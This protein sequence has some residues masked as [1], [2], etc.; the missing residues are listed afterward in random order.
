MENRLIFLIKGAV[1]EDIG[2]SL[3]Y[4]ARHQSRV[5]WG[6]ETLMVTGCWLVEARLRLLTR[7]DPGPVF[8]A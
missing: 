6:G 4:S 7:G 5:R 2:F 1:D 8:V 3:P